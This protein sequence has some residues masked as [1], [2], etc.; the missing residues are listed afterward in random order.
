MK[1]DRAKWTTALL[2]V[3]S[4][5]VTAS[6][7]DGKAEDASV[8]D[9][10]RIA[11]SVSPFTDSQ[12]NRGI[13]FEDELGNRATSTRELQRLFMAHGANEVYVR[14][15]TDR[16]ATGSDTDHSLELGIT[17][18]K[19]AAELGLPLNP[20]IALFKTYGDVAGQPLP[21]FSE[22]PEIDM[23]RRW[24]ELTVDEMLPILKQYGALVAKELTATGAK[25]NSWNIGNE[26]DFGTAG[27]AVSPA[28]GNMALYAPPDVIDPSIGKQDV[29]ALLRMDAAQRNAWLERYLWP[30]QARLMAA[31]GEGIRSVVPDAKLSTHIAQGAIP[32]FAVAFYRAMREG[33]FEVDVAGFSLYPTSMDAP[34]SRIDAFLTTVKEMKKQLNLPSFL[35]EYAY[36][37]KAIADGPY[38]EWSNN[39]DGRFELNEAGQAA[40]L[41]YLTSEGI[42]SG[43]VGIRPWAPDF[44]DPSWRELSLFE[45]RASVEEG[46]SAVA[47]PAIDSISQGLGTPGR[48]RDQTSKNS[49]RK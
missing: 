5:L 26:V 31:V 39:K 35:A 6:F 27:V 28:E 14:I 47:R 25:I 13:A 46:I 20:E 3:P 33:G 22:Y 44:I 24:Q 48:K 8:V 10:F 7:S 18:A 32:E 41:R 1:T 2:L 37:A 19:L 29:V 21:D 4:L 30:H 15:A 49:F 38:A 36:P 42:E 40:A 34:S 17:R 16:Y 23:P 45:A 43:L 12:M 11:L 9:P